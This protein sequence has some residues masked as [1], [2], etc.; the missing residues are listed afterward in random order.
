MKPTLQDLNKVI[1]ELQEEF[2]KA[3]NKKES[4]K[5]RW[6]RITKKAGKTDFI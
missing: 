2:I 1:K 5:K 6:N 3:I 4:R